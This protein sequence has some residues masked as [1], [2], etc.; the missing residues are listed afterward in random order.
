MRLALVLV[1]VLI[2]GCTD[3]ARIDRLPD[4][5]P[6]GDLRSVHVGTTRA[7]D[8]ETGAHGRG[9]ASDMQFI[10]YEVSIPPERETGAI[11]RPRRNQ[12]FD[13]ER[14]FGVRDSIEMDA[15]EYRAAVRRRLA[16]MPS[17][18]RESI[19][20]VHGFNTTFIEGVYRVA[21]MSND[22]TLPGVA[23]HYSWPSLGAPLAYAHDRDSALFARDGLERMIRETA[24]ATSGRVILIGHSMGGHLVMETLRQ[25]AISGNRSLLDRIG[26]VMLISPD[27]DVELFRAQAERIG[28]LPRPFLIVS[29]QR[30]RILQLSAR[31][32]GQRERLGNIS[33]PEVIDG[34]GVTVLDVSAFSTGAGHFTVG[35][36][37]ALIQLLGQVGAVEAALG[38]EQAGRLPLLPATILT[39]QNTTQII[40]E[41][42]TDSRRTMPRLEQALADE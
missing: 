19:I 41:P 21:Q 5:A 33:D 7:I 24:A 37:P 31:L 16:E 11:E 15:A 12:P 20:F 28:E 34:L 6:V 18:Q 2:A 9:R 32:T 29:S 13:P 39:L 30:D 40:L 25:I 23:L 35:S 36:S 17:D 22:L 4:D 42:L 8:P 3:R 1:V 38:D 14:H 27:I 26:G 10:Q